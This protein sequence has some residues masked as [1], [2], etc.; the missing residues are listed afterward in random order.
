[1]NQKQE[2]ITVKEAAKM[3][4]VA[5]ST[6]YNWISQGRIQAKRVGPWMLRVKV[7]DVKRVK[8]DG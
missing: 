1:M 5:P 3:L 4:G 7:E 6:I 8:N 2:F